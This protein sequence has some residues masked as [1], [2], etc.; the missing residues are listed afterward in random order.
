MG[1]CAP[2][3]FTLVTYCPFACYSNTQYKFILFTQCYKIVVGE[4]KK[5]W[6]E[7]RTDCLNQG[8]NLVSIVNERV[9]GERFLFRC[10]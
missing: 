8:G 9:Q 10:L 5:N 7:A 4:D 1:K 6:Q 3:F 2:I